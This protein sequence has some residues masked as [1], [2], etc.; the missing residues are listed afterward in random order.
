MTAEE[1][2]ALKLHFQFIGTTW[3]EWEERQRRQNEPIEDV[4]PNKRA[5]MVVLQNGEHVVREH[6]LW[7]FPEVQAGRQLGDEL[8]YAEEQPVAPVA[9]L[10][11]SMRS[12]GHGL[13]G[14]G[15]DHASRRDDVAVVQAEGRPAVL[16]RRDLASL[17]R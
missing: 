16:L 10:R 11:A 8:P 17:D 13:C 9:R 3:T 2:R 5:P 14:A 15:Q 4:Y 12:A 7:G 6:M 1:M